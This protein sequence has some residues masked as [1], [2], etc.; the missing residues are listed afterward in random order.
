M[1]THTVKLNAALDRRLTMEA[2]RLKL[3]KSEVTRFALDK[4]RK[5]D[6]FISVHDRMKDVCGIIKDGPRD[7]ATNPKYMKDFGK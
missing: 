7:L 1:K 4:L 3:S 2:K 5:G 6:T